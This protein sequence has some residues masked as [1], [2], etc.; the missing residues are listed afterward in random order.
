MPQVFGLFMLAD[1]MPIYLLSISFK[2]SMIAVVNRKIQYPHEGADTPLIGKGACVMDQSVILSDDTNSVFG[3]WCF[4]ESVVL[5][6]KKHALQR[7]KRDFDQ[8]RKEFE[9]EKRDFSARQKQEAH[10]LEQEKK[11]F[12][13]K[14]KILEEELKK[15]A[16]EKQQFEKQKEFYRYVS[17]HETREQKQ[18]GTA[19]ICGEL[20]FAGAESKQALKKRYKDLIKIYH[21]DNLNG[22]TGTIKE[23]N[24]EYDRLMQQY[25]GV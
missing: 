25:D 14:W 13:M 24:R 2:W 8:K 11:L 5:A 18:R 3:Q 23:I 12:E 19:V 22:D 16:G 21:P 10:R 9:K 17:E 15:F 20:F 6:H 1:F 7:R 4:N